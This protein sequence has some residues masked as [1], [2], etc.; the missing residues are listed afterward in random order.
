MKQFEFFNVRPVEMTDGSELYEVITP[1]GERVAS[2]SEHWRAI[3]LE[4]ALN[5]ALSVAAASST[6]ISV[7]AEAL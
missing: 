4:Q 6:D 7:N 1:D 3:G 2:A 5:Q